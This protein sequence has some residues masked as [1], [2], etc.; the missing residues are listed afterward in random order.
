ML[1]QF[2]GLIGLLFLGIIALAMS[3]MPP[4]TGGKDLVVVG[5]SLIAISFVG[6]AVAYFIEWKA[7][8]KA[9]REFEESQ[10]WPDNFW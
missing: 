3:R 2:F 8:R 6:Q 10:K 9:S 7:M 4:P 1:Q 5:W